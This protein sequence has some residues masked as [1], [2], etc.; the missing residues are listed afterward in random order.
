MCKFRNRGVMM[1]ILLAAATTPVCATET[2][3]ALLHAASRGGVYAAPAAAELE[4]A[5]ALFQQCFTGC[6]GAAV[7]QGWAELGFEVL[8]AKH[9]ADS[10]VVLREQPD[11]RLGRGF[12]VF[13]PRSNSTT[14]L[15]APHSF[16]DENTREILLNLLDD[17]G[18]RAAAWNTVPRHYVL[19]GATVDA[20]MAHLKGSYFLAFSRAFARQFASGRLVQLHGFAGE[21][22]RTN[23]GTAAAI[24]IS[25]GSAEV[26]PAVRDTSHCLQRAGL[27]EVRVYPTDIRELGATTNSTG[28]ALRAMGHAGFIHLELS[29]TTRRSLLDD[30]A[31]RTQLLHCLKR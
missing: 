3:S 14:V 21:K 19:N 20:D 29:A 24:V 25:S 5:Q 11:A 18:F 28:Q 31:S 17:G 26:T 27:G 8:Q 15:Q 7:R 2:V 9:G 22:R 13:R 12:Y 16:K 1:V 4:R 30:Q 23:S 6:D 10:L